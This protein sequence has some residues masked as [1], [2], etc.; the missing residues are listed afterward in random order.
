MNAHSTG[1]FILGYGLA[2]G[3]HSLMYGPM[4]AFLAE[5]F[6]TRNALYRGLAGLPARLRG[7]RRTGS[8]IA[9]TSLLA[10]GGGAPHALYVSCFMA[11]SCAVTALAVLLT[12]ETHQKELGA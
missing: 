11:G 12:R 6:G 5:L 2:L 9:A 4:G 3:L 1:L 10:A 8:Q 7:G